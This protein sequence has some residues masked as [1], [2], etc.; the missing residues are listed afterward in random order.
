MQI[1]GVHV[2]IGENGVL[3]Q[4]GKRCRHAGL[5]GAAL[6]AE[7]DEMEGNLPDTKDI[8]F[9]LRVSEKE[10]K[11]RMGRLISWLY[12]DDIKLISSCY[13]KNQPLR[14][15][16]PPETETE[17][18]TE[19]ETEVESC[20]T[21]GGESLELF[22]TPQEAS[23][24]VE[25]LTALPTVWNALAV[26]HGLSKVF[27]DRDGNAVLE[28]ERLKAATK[29]WKTSKVYRENWKDA[30]QGISKSPFHLGSNDRGWK[31]DIDFFLRQSKGKPANFLKF[32]E[33]GKTAKD[34]EDERP[35]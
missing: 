30:I 1:G 9:R 16:G 20:Q 33:L 5:A 11:D 18:E 23:E 14:Q 35:F 29:L 27:V 21:F 24:L 32:L 13:K 31:I 25:Y 17:T 7:D 34:N 6:A 19:V 15:V 10:V 26:K 22:K 12:Q 4:R 3:R 8:A 28:G 2:G